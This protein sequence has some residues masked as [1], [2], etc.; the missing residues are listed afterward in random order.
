PGANL[1]RAGEDFA[2]G[3]AVLKAGQRLRPQE[4]GM[5]AAVGRQSL[6][7][8]RR[9]RVGVFSTGDEI[10]DP[11]QPPRDG[12]IYDVNRFTVMAM[13]GKLGGEAVDLGILADRRDAVTAALA[14]AAGRYD[15]LLTSGGVS[16]GD[17]DHVRSAVESL[18]SMD[19]WR[20]A[21][22]PGRPLACGRV[23]DTPLLGLPGNPVASMVCFMIFARPLLMHLAGRDD[24]QL[25]SRRV[26]AG[27]DFKK[28]PGRRE[29]L[30]GWL[31]GE[32]VQRFPNEGSG[33]L[34]S[35]TTATG[36]IDLPEDLAL[37]SAGDP[38]RFVPFAELWD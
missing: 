15:L 35:M 26:A 25:P 28:K 29:W 30:R 27:F 33:I 21:I 16:T 11:G 10:L 24:W 34:S 38:L 36:L 32:T 22:R 12:A 13:I 9:P 14:A 37:I 20:V 17:E 19:F 23:G 31:D 3:T 7:L 4:I 6:T 5:A 18:G 1:R 2:V 8:R